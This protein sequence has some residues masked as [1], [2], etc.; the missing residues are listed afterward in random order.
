MNN[1]AVG[2]G[3]ALSHVRQK[4]LF[5]FFAYRQ[6]YDSR[7]LSGGIREASIIQTWQCAAKFSLPDFLINFRTLSASK[8][9]HCLHEAAMR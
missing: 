3:L 9:I 8:R 1:A 5:V 6:A 4:L 7:C 2:S